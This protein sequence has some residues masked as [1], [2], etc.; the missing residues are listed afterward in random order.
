MYILKFKEI[1]KT[2]IWG[3]NKI[4]AFKGKNI[5]LASV[6]ESWEIS[7]VE[8]DVSIVANG[9][10]AGKSLQELVER[11]G[12]RLMGEHVAR[13]FGTTF[14][15]LVKFI[16][17]HDNLSIQVHPDDE[18]ARR[19]HNSFGKTE[20]WYV[21]SAEPDAGLYSGLAQAITPDEYM[22][23]VDDNTIM[24]VLQFHNV[25]A[26]DVFY[27]PSG[28]IHAIGRGVFIAEIQQTS[29][30]T[31][32]IYDYNRIGNDGRPRELHTEYARDAIDYKLY[33]DLKTQYA[34]RKNDAVELVDCPY[35]TTSLLD[36]DR[37]TN[38]PVAIY[39]SFVVY[40]CMQG[41]VR[42]EANNGTWVELVQGETCLVPA[43]IES[44]T[45]TPSPHVKMLES[46]VRDERMR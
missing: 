37:V 36:L 22:Q 14:P 2:P 4:A 7:A 38:R 28:R 34:P 5:D 41:S 29:N 21:I 32:R 13:Y 9:E 18:L 20:M 1:Y 39:D 10:D 43:E 27:L 17:A 12:E 3:G 46:Y 44:V 24:E 25:K 35:F 26:D 40:V 33:D 30:V 8:G 31:Y 45:L 15:L 11:D 42:I 6:G 19:R 16:D 23:R